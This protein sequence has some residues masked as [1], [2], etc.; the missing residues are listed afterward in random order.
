[1]H[2][3]GVGDVT[4]HFVRIQIDDHHVGGVGD[5][6]ASRG[7]VHGQV[8]PTALAANLD[9]AHRPVAGRG[10]SDQEWQRQDEEL[11]HVTS[12]GI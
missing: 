12:T 7:A 11:S 9:L 2:S 4:H 1:M 6:E 8:I 3:R 5:V 10:R